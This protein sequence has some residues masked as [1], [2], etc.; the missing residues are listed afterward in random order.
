[1]KRALKVL[2]FAVCYV[3]IYPFVLIGLLYVAYLLQYSFPYADF[4]A[5]VFGNVLMVGLLIYFR[6]KT[7]DSWIRA[8]AKKWL[9]ERSRHVSP[10]V[11]AARMR[12]RGRLLWIPS[13]IALAIFLFFPETTGLVSR[14][15]CDSSVPMNQYHLKIPLTWIVMSRSSS[16]AFVIA[17]KGIGRAGLR[18]YWRREIPISEIV[19]YV[20]S[21]Y[22]STDDFLT[23]AKVLSQRT[24]RLG[25]ETLTCWDIIPNADRQ[26]TPMDNSF[27][28]IR[29]STAQNDFHTDFVGLRRESSTFY[30]ELQ[31]VTLTK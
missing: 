17:G 8:E 15:F 18:P 6:H 9:A 12:S 28:V 1:V 23:H 21:P 29:C 22:P 7:R 4:V 2:A 16:S 24:L 11:R 26:P 27:A 31:S 25:Q 14:L 5:F 13:G 10:Q 20:T 30:D 3:V 19:F